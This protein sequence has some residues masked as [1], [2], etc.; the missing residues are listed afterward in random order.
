MMVAM[1]VIWVAFAI[2]Q[3]WMGIGDNVVRTI[4]GSTTGVL[5]GQIW[6]L[7]TAP[8]FHSPQQPW[9]LLTTLLGLYF[10]GPTLEERWGVRRTLIFLFGAAA[11]AFALQVVIGA[12]VPQLH[13]SI[14]F[15]GLGMET[16]VAVAW[17][18]SNRGQTVR[19]FFM[20]PVSATA[21]I[22]LIFVFALVHVLSMSGTAEGLVTPFGGMLGGWLFGDQSPLRRFY[23]KLRLKQIQA[24]NAAMRAQSA[25]RSRRANAPFRVIEGGTKPPPKDKRYL[26]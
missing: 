23:L 14:W 12:L 18:L 21:L 6:R 2:G 20:I 24:E 11:F 4:V 5:H 9:H 16:A 22:G 25:A 17:A 7:F 26:N 3:N 1:T 10:L 19:L 13:A 15:G 8:L